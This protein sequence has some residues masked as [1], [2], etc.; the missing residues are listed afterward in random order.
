MPHSRAAERAL[1]CAPLALLALFLAFAA[2][3]SAPAATRTFTATADTFV[4]SGRPRANFG[5]SM[6]L[7]VDA[8]PVRRGYVR[9]SVF[10][11]SG[12][13][14]KA[15][16]RLRSKNTRSVGFSV[17]SVASTTWGETTLTYANAPAAGTVLAS[18]V[19]TSR[20]WGSANVTSSVTGNRAVSFA[21][22]SAATRELRLSSRE[23]GS[24]AAPQLVIETRDEVAAPPPPPPPPPPVPP[25]G[26]G[27]PAPNCLGEPVDHPLAAYPEQRIFYEA[28]GWWAEKRADGSVAKLGDAEHIHVASCVPE[29]AGAGA[30]RIDVRVMGHMLPAGSEITT[31]RL[32]EDGGAGDILTLD[33]N[34]AIAPGE[35]DTGSLWRKADVSLEGGE[36]RYLTKV[37]RP[38]LDEIHASTG[39]QVG[40]LARGSVHERHS[41]G[42]Y[43]CHEY[44]NPWVMRGLPFP[45]TGVPAGQAYSFPVRYA[46]GAGGPTYIAYGETRLDPNLH[47]GNNGILLDSWTGS[48]S[49]TSRTVTI[50]AE[51]M[52][53]GLHKIMVLTSRNANCD[54]RDG[55]VTGV[56]VVPLKVN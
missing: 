27:D 31:T 5:R 3:D 46:D 16:L 56:M 14:T 12:P 39:W 36:L 9:F 53:P 34:R 23:A 17:R 19:R 18:G 40:P 24:G 43:T 26:V 35:V 29:G 52:T 55:E 42:W 15:T 51:H 21:V 22:T 6:T 20:G 37:V 2:A 32:H 41:R 13:I 44:A 11:L 28:Q 48:A 30:Y 8:S 7:K 4:H 50:P 10:G 54:G 45:V 25:S 49:S 47:A 38:D 33:W 1:P